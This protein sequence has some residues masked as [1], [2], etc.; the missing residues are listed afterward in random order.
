MR[1]W[2]VAAEITVRRCVRGQVLKKTANILVGSSVLALAITATAPVRAQDQQQE[3][4]VGA[5]ATGD[6]SQDV[7]T[8]VVTAQKREQNLQDVPVSISVITGENLVDQGA[9]SLT[10]YA[11]YVPGLS[12]DSGGTP[13]LSTVTLR[14]ISPTTSSSAVGYYLDEVPVGSSSIYAR[15]SELSLDLLPY[16][17]ERIEVLRGPQGTLYGASSIGGLLKYV[18]VEP[19]LTRFSARAGAEAFTINGADDMGWAAQAMVNAPLAQ[20][21]AGVTGSF[22]YRKTPGWVDSIQTDAL[23]DEN[24]YEQMGGRLSARV[25]ASEAFSIEL[26]AIFQSVDADNRGVYAASLDGQRLGNGRSNN[27]FLPEPFESDFQFYSATLE[28]DMGPVAFTSA[29][30]YSDMSSEQGLDAS[31]VFGSLFPLLTGGAIPAGLTPLTY[32]VDL[33]KFTQEVRLAS[34]GD[35][36]F[37]WLVGAFYTHEDSL[38]GQVIRSFDV[39]GA[40]VAPLDPLAIVSLPATYQEYAFFGNATLELGERFEI[41]GGLRWARNE[42]DFRQVSSGAVVPVADDPGESSESNFTFSISPQFNLSEDAMIYGRVATGYRPGGPNVIVPGVPPTVSAD[43]LTNYEVGVKADLAGGLATVDAAAFYMDWNDIQVAQSFG[44]IGGLANGGRATSK[45]LEGALTVRP[46]AGLTLGF[47]AAYTDAT[48]SEDVA[49]ISGLDG[50][51]LPNVPK[52][53]GSARV[54]YE[55]PVNDRDMVR[56]GAGVRHASSRLSLV[57]SDPLAVSARAYTSVDLNAGY[58]FD[59]R[60]TVRFYARN[61]FDDNGEYSRSIT[62]DGLNQPAFISITP[63]QPRTFGIAAEL[64]L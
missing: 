31:L 10:D 16:D 37:S 5:D 48:L 29:S 19:S 1:N 12:I 24:D 7:P 43:T 60:W 14:G 20:D 17:I 13:G 64:A 50:D 46:S 11:G 25:L 45:G 28:Y 41:T 38:Q 51:R 15:A 22:S 2:D 26:N 40:P 18:T 54:D 36:A 33:E 52:F 62:V 58:T 23:R 21:R 35:S 49:A 57:E 3:Q 32:S 4:T 55:L 8:I 56:F 63:L 61:L 39:A 9:T 42:Q 47:T 53:G 27:N 44:G 30:S 6:V 59:D 34:T